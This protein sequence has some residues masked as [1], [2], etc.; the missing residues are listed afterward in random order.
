MNLR[1]CC[2]TYNNVNNGRSVL[3]YWYRTIVNQS[4]LSLTLIME[5]KVSLIS[6]RSLHND[7]HIICLGAIHQFF[8]FPAPA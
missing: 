4:Y 8:G 2:S 3:R 6:L 7:L 5:K 1:L